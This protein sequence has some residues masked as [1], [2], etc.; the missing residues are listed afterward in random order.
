[1]RL[2]LTYCKK[3]YVPIVLY[4]VF[5]LV[6]YLFIVFKATEKLNFLDVLFFLYGSPILLIIVGVYLLNLWVLNFIFRMVK[7]VIL[8]FSLFMFYLV[9]VYILHIYFLHWSVNFT[10]YELFIYKI[11]LIYF[12]YDKQLLFFVFIVQY[13]FYYKCLKQRSINA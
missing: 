2:V 11:R 5:Q 9:M 12:P 1:M 6:F 8:T 10:I 4:L 3:Q 7:K 13:F